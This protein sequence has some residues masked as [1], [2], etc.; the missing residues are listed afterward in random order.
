MHVYNIHT[1]AS[2]YRMR[3]LRP[4]LTCICVAAMTEH[5]LRRELA[6]AGGAPPPAA[7]FQV[8]TR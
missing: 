4:T 8:A 3:H 6:I 2:K 7:H 5:V 1:Y